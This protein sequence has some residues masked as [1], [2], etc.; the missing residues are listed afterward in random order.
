[1]AAGKSVDSMLSDAKRVLKHAQDFDNSI[2]GAKHE[3]SSAPYS[4]VKKPEPPKS[5]GIA[6]E[7]KDVAAGIKVKQDMAKKLNSQ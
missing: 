2:P 4:L 1:M 7:T 6:D 3:Y 5:Y